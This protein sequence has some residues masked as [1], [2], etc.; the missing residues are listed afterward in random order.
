MRKELNNTA[1][2]SGSFTV[3]PDLFSALLGAWMNDKTPFTLEQK[4]LVQN[5]KHRKRRINK[6]WAKRYGFHEEFKSLGK[7]QIEN[8]R[9]EGDITTTTLRSVNE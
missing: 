2:F 3:D 4:I 8:T 5:R 1:E 9:V 6:K 7:Y